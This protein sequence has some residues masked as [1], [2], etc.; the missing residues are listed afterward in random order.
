[1]IGAV[2]PLNGKSL[3]EATRP[4]LRSPSVTTSAGRKNGETYP[5]PPALSFQPNEKK[6]VTLKMNDLTYR[7]KGLTHRAPVN[8]SKTKDLRFYDSLKLPVFAA[9]VSLGQPTLAEST[10]RLISAD[11]KTRP[12]A[13]TGNRDWP[14][15]L[16]AALPVEWRPDPA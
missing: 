16:G 8:F 3:D 1:M 10:L 6:Q 14:T 11:P 4:A 9:F 2:Y 15:S 13:K 5:T 7:N 12:T